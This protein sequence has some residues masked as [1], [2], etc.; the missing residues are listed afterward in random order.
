[1]SMRRK[2]FALMLGATASVALALTGPGAGL[3]VSGSADLRI[4][5]ADSPDPVAAGATLTYS[6]EVDNLGPNAATGVR[7][8]DQL[9]KEVD[10][11]S[12]TVSGGQCTSKGRK[13]T[14][15]L[16]AIPVVTGA[17]ATARTVTI[18]VIPRK[19]GTISNT[20]SVKGA[21]KDPAKAND[22]ATATTRVVGPGPTCRGIPVT[23]GGTRGN[24][25]LVGSGGR[26][27]VAGFGGDDTIYAFAG[28]DLVCAGSGNDHVGGGT[29]ADR[30]FGA[31]GADRL[32]GRGGPDLLLGNAGPDLLR[33]NRG[34]DRL[35]GGSGSDRCQGGAG[36][37]S[38]RGCER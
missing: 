34:A 18:A 9:P 37:D 31:A 7:V 2:L 35:R 26:D 23:L 22:K 36:V 27:V 29:A 17:Y 19:V 5:K 20:A 30:V 14:C 38:V 1:M 12:A 21:E 11:V 15:D 6:V 10:L 8:T 24:D 4:V 16:G 32:L 25:V 33:G 3:A 13:V 28:R